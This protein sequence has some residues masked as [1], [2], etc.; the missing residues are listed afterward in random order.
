MKEIQ[1]S[2]YF[3]ILIPKNKMRK[4]GFTLVEMLI[5]IVLIG[6]LASAIMPRLS[7]AIAR[8]RDL[9]RQTDLKNI[10][11]AI[12]IYYEKRGELP[13]IEITREERTKFTNIFIE[14]YLPYLGSPKTLQHKLHGY[15]SEIPSDPQKS[16]RVCIYWD[17]T[18]SSQANNERVIYQNISVQKGEY[19][20]QIL[21]NKGRDN[22][23]ALLIAK[24][25]TPD[26]ANYIV[27]RPEHV[28]SSNFSYNGN[29]FTHKSELNSL[30]KLKLCTSVDKVKKWE[31]KF[32]IKID[33]KVE[34]SYSSEDQL[35]YLVPIE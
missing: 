34:C 35:Y 9:K 5:V 19:L 11:T 3:I 33:W 21:K 13:L 15:L 23:W 30:E 20:Y 4:F 26:I 17:C 24:V 25:E 31:E 10:A 29:Y 27:F 16:S 32:E 12:Q 14:K 8:S 18:F 1:K 28:S 7:W 22:A 2:L 6:I